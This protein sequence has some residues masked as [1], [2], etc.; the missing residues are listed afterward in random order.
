MIYKAEGRKYTIER[1]L[2]FFDNF[3]VIDGLKRNVNMTNASI[4]CRKINLGHLS[5][6]FRGKLF[7]GQV[8]VNYGQPGQ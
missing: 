8:P 5:L 2:G 6:R 7:L 3:H 1:N 4:N